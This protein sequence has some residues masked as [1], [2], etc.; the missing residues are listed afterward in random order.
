[1]GAGEHDDVDVARR[2]AASNSGRAAARTVV[3]AD[4]G[5]AGELAPRQLD[6][7][8]RAVADDALP[9][10]KSAREVVDIGLADGRLGAEQADDAGSAS[11]PRRA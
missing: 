10:A 11:S 8:G 3:D 6:Q 9:A 2:P 1:M 5:F 7:L 4:T